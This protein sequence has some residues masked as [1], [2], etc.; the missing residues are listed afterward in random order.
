MKKRKMLMFALLAL[1]ESVVAQTVTV[2]DVEALPGETVSFSVSLSDGK[3]NTYTAM[4]L[5]A[6]FPATGFTTTGAYT[7]ASS[8]T[9]VSC[10]VGDVDGT[11]LATIPF[12]SSNAIP[13]T[14]VDNLVTV[15]FTVGA[16]V[17]V[18]DYDVTLA[19]TMFEYG[20][21]GKDYASDVTFQVHVVSAHT[22]VLDEN[23]TIVP[24]NATGVNARVLRTINAGNWSTICLPFAMTEAQTKA[25][26]GYEVELANFTGYTATED[27]GNIV[28]IT[29]N[30]SEA[31][32]IE[33]NH[34]YII[35]VSSPVTEFTVD[36]V[37]VSPAEKPR[38]EYK[39]GKKFLSAFVGTYVANFNFY[40][41]AGEYYPLF[42]SGNKFYYATEETQLM[43]GFRAY[44]VFKDNLPEAEGSSVKMLV[45]LDGEE[46]GI[47]NLDANVNNNSMIYDLSGRRVSKPQKGIYI[48]NG[49]KVMY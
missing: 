41:D 12:A 25:A 36:N 8:W 20:T 44:F 30:F 17:A 33:A 16:G 6:K 13:G 4:T 32:A 1:G 28:G 43:K 15:S 46:T 24:S 42:L 45:D 10:T 19:G 14:A 38:V 35:K 11:G 7:V 18:G 31:T 29:V 3:A 2:P 48:V 47:E 49:K 40:E 34:P 22:V 39:S 37:S 27:G 9:G 23:S 26:F 5:Y 21:S